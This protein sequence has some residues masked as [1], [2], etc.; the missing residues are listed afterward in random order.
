[1]C[2][3]TAVQKRPENNLDEAPPKAFF[4][5]NAGALF[6]YHLGHF[7]RNPDEYHTLWVQGALTVEYVL[8]VMT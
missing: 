3:V 7:L 8:K 1:V 5:Y 2:P 6:D 4:M